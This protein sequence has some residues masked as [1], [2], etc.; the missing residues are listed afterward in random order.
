MESCVFF[1]DDAGLERYDAQF[2]LEMWLRNVLLT[3]VFQKRADEFRVGEDGVFNRIARGVLKE[4]A[5]PLGY[6]YDT[7]PSAELK[8]RWFQEAGYVVLY[9]ANENSAAAKM[10]KRALQKKK[11]VFAFKKE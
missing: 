9:I 7:A 4:S 2:D 6:Y 3:L 10:E 1:G 5:A 8:K 11:T